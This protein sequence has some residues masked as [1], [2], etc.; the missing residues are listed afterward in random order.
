MV[1]KDE[2]ESLKRAYVKNPYI[3]L[4]YHGTYLYG[5]L[6]IILQMQHKKR[7]V[8]KFHKSVCG[9]SLFQGDDRRYYHIC[10]TSTVSP[11]GFLDYFEANNQEVTSRFYDPADRFDSFIFAEK[12]NLN[13][14]NNYIEWV[15]WHNRN[16]N[17]KGS[18]DMCRCPFECKK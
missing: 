14:G 5:Y 15:S 9:S 1:R 11:A 16:A 6:Q 8:S 17:S 13:Y 18:Y 4:H 7:T 2:M 10:R 12:R 3:T